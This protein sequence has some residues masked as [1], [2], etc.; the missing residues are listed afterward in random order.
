[1]SK[2]IGGAAPRPAE[3]YV[4]VPPAPD[5]NGN[6][7]QRRAAKP[8]RPT[9][10][11][12]SLLMDVANGLVRRV[13]TTDYRAALPAPW[14]VTGRVAELTKAGWAARGVDGIYAITPAGQDVIAETVR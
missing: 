5:P 2:S 3:M 6:R 9:R 4:S 10:A 7:A 11:R 1:M 12:V 8:I 14:R 13:G